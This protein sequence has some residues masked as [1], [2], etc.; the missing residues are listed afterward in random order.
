M[1]FSITRR[2]LC[3]LSAL[4]GTGSSAAQSKKQPNILVLMADQQS[5]HALGCYGDT[6]VK[7]PNLDRLA[8]RGVRFNNAYCQAPLCVPSRMSFLTG[9]QPSA[10]RV[11]ANS[12][13]L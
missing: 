11:W 5:P 4:A 6:I 3:Y 2:E 8:A 1:S 7:S 9:R 13:S 12:C 10:N